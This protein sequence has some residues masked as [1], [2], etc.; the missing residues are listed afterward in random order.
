MTM[1][2]ECERESSLI[3]TTKHIDSYDTS[4]VVASS[5]CVVSEHIHLLI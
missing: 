2:D 1:N 3:A 4:V 5:V